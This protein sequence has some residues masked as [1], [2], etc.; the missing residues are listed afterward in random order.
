M[1][2]SKNKKFQYLFFFI[3]SIYT[4]FNGG[5]S[6]TSIQINFIL[7]SLLFLYCIKD[8]NYNLH[9]KNFYTK[10][11]ISFII[12]LFFLF[13]L[14]FQMIPLPIEFLKLFSPAKYNLINNLEI[15]SS[16]SSIS[17]VPSNTFFQIINFISML[18]LVFIL[19]MTFYNQRHKN[20]LYLFLSF[21]GFLSSFIAIIFYFSGNPDFFIF[22]NSYYKYSSTGFFINRTVFAIFLLFCLISS[23]ELLKNFNI[24]STQKKDNFFLK[25]YI[26]LFV[27]FITV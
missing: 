24:K 25:I 16:Y 23:L 3:I 19:K 2:L 4:I 12:Y 7:I 10:N 14:I 6:D 26:R 22:K 9:F 8:K 20:R 5:N 1:Q 13:Y 15:E 11:K 27:I 17:I 21:F 18:I